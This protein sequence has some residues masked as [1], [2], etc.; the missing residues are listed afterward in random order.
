MSHKNHKVA[1]FETFKLL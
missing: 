1:S